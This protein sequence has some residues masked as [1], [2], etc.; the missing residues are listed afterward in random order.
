MAALCALCALGALAPS[1]SAATHKTSKSSDRG[2]AAVETVY[3]PLTAPDPDGPPSL[4]ASS[5]PAVTPRSQPQP[6]DDRPSDSRR[7]EPSVSVGLDRNFNSSVGGNIGFYSAE[8]L[9]NNPF[10]NLFYDLYPSAEQP[11]FF[12]FT[13]GLGTAQSSLSKSQIGGQDFR[14]NIMLALEA[15]VGYTY[16]DLSHALG[17]AGG[18]YPYF[19]GGMVVL[20][21]G[22]VPG[23]GGV[24]NIGGVLGFGN[25]MNLPFGLKNHQWAL[26]YEIRDHIYSQK[27]T[28]ESS[29]TQNF[30]LLVG[31]QKYY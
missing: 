22:G 9:G 26:N 7:T 19:D 23:M 3:V 24:P 15:L 6:V 21:Q 1:A 13:G 5:R 30:I 2:R 27:F 25:R 16:T 20:Y 14:N 17:R 29:F 4:T 10:A 8:V 31:V 18:L 11:Y 12:E 28:T